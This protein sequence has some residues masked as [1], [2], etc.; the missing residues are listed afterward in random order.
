MPCESIYI[1]TKLEGVK[2]YCHN[3]PS[4]HTSHP[5]CRSAGGHRGAGLLVLAKPCSLQVVQRGVIFHHIYF[6]WIGLAPCWA[7]AQSAQ[8][9]L[10][11]PV[12]LFEML[13]SYS[14]SLHSKPYLSRE[15]LPVTQ[16]D[17]TWGGIMRTDTTCCY[18]A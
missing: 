17:G 2:Y 9:L 5:L 8:C 15:L 13:L 1:C 11:S 18:I 14:G 16:G 10:W 7:F 3:L 4:V 6:S 12:V